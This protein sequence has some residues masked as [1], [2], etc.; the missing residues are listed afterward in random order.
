M[1]QGTASVQEYRQAQRVGAC[2]VAR[3]RMLTEKW[4]LMCR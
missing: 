2:I 1:Q 4:E 3:E